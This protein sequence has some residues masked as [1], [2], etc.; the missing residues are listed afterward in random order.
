MPLILSSSVNWEH[1][2]PLRR[3]PYGSGAL[4]PPLWDALWSGHSHPPCGQGRLGHGSWSQHGLLG[5]CERPVQSLLRGRALGS[6]SLGQ[7][8]AG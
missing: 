2:H 3:I 6:P 1:S 4:T 5:S 7:R 8:G